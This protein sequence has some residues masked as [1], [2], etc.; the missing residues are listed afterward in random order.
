[1][2]KLN[3][4]IVLVACSLFSIVNAQNFTKA[5][6]K[7]TAGHVITVYAKPTVS[8]VASGTSL[9]ISF[10][11]SLPG[12]TGPASLTAAS[13]V[14]APISAAATE[15]LNGRKHYP[16]LIEGNSNVALTLNADNPIATIT[17][18]ASEDGDVVQL[19]D[20]AGSGNSNNVYWYISYFGAD[21]TDYSGRFYGP[22]AN[23]GADSYVEANHPLPISL[24]SFK[25]EKFQERS[26][27]LTWTTVSEINSS[28]FIV[29]R[30]TDKK[31]WTSVG[32]VNAAGN[33]QFV[34]N[35]E[36]IDQN[37]YNGID[38]RLSVYYRLQMVDLDGQMKN[39]PL[40]NVIF[41]NDAGKSS[42]LSLLVYPNPA[43]DGVQVEW[44][45]QNDVQPTLLEL[46]DI[47]GKLV[48]SQKVSENANQEYIDFGL[49]K[50][51]AGVY[52]LRILNGTEPI[53]HQQIVVGHS[54]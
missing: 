51:D 16:F 30:S 23:N 5:T 39:S 40:E 11:V 18:P 22:G 9:N 8:T 15:T 34:E 46:Y 19:N 42:D 29:Q 2:K 53:E 1:M 10:S 45:A 36:F 32:K 6:L 44:N 28:H 13:L 27:Y 12:S 25:A 20:L 31:V 21:A 14:G 49:A 26:T 43:S 4:I 38:S 7:R 3:I 47:T 48:L 50:I 24:V 37:V 54:R 33:S 17:F 41:G 35:Y 52:L